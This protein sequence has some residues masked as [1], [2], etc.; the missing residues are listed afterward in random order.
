MKSWAVTRGPS[1]DPNDK[2]L[3]VQVEDHPIEYN[4]FEG[5]IPQ[6]QY[7][8]GTVMIWD[9]GRWIPEN[10][11]HKGFAKGHL[12]FVLDGEKLHGRWHLVRMRTRAG[13]RHN[14]WLLI[15]GNDEDARSGK[16]SDILARRAAVGG[17]RPFHGGDRRRQR[18][19]ARLAEQS[20]RQKSF[21]QARTANPARVPRAIAG[22]T[23]AR[24]KTKG[25][26]KAAR[27]PGQ[28]CGRAKCAKKSDPPAAH[29]AAKA[30]DC[31]TSFR[32]ASPRCT[33]MRRAARNGCTKSNSTATASKRGSIAAKCGCSRA[34]DW[35]GRRAFNRSP[36]RS[37]HF[38]PRPR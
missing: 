20:E 1:L 30:P 15:K 14:N 5:T 16:G 28:G 13:D 33:P 12:D 2:R 11:P 24:A 29:A 18:Q 21:G 26:A 31:R 36:M 38:P 8:G 23:T 3:A 9:R 17:E 6:G 22:A 34:R 7:G 37:Q 32:R 35:I 19:K 25:K 10:D 27:T 4:S